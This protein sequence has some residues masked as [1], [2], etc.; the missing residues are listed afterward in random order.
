MN[1]PLV[2]LESPYSGDIDR[3]IRYLDLA[4]VDS[5]LNYNECPY[6]SHAVMTRHPRAK[7]YFVSDYDDKWNIL[8]RDNAIKV[9]QNFRHVCTKSVFIQIL[10][11]A[12][13]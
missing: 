2:M 5:E 1:N 4:L 13:E 10:V 6:A 3:N 12:E 11:G 8:T 7:S 9:S